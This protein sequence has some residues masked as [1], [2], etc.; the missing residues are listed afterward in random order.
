MASETGRTRAY[1]HGDLRRALI[2]TALQILQEE[3]NWEFTLRE[4]ARRAGVSHAAPYKHFSDK[5]ELLA[6]VAAVGFRALQQ[7]MEKAAA[8][9]E[10]EPEELLAVLGETYVAFALESPARFRLMFGPVR[11][12][13]PPVPALQAAAR[14]AFESLRAAVAGGGGEQVDIRTLAA[15]SLVHGLATLLIDR[16]IPDVPS[17]AAGTRA[18]VAQ[19]I[20]ASVRAPS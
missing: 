7:A 16:R 2:D 14:E 1:H 12:D 5:R 4:L 8:G 3:Q 19:I 11:D 17:D 15:W 10:G 18:L 9:H 20:R 6:E 13:E